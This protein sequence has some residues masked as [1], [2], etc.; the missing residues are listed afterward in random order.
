MVGA[1][2]EMVSRVVKDLELRG[3]I[4]MGEGRI[5]LRDVGNA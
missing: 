3:L 5:V 1:S 2:R 4:E